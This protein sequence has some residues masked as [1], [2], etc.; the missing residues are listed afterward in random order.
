LLTSARY[1]DDAAAEAHKNGP[2]L[3]KFVEIE[4][5]EGN[6]AAP[7]EVMPLEHFTGFASR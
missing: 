1:A 7:L 2:A 3:A 4:K 6:L 5:Q